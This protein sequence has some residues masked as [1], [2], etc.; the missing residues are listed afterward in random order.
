MSNPIIDEMPTMTQVEN[1]DAYQLV[2]WHLWLRP[3]MMNSELDVVKA[4][5]RRV[6]NMNGMTRDGLVARARHEAT[7]R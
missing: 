4:I 1:A 5:T 2:K 6:D 7:T 3:T